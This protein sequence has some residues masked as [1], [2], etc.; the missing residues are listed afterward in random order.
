VGSKRYSGSGGKREAQKRVKARE[1]G[2]RWKVYAPI[3]T[4]LVVIG[5]VLALI[6][7]GPSVGVAVGDVAPNSQFTLLNGTTTQLYNFKG[8]YLLL[9]FI[10]TWCDGC[11]EGLNQLSSY[12]PMLQARGVQVL[13]LE[14]YNDL[15]YPGMELGKFVKQFGNSNFTA[16][17]ASYDMTLKYNS[18][19]YPDV[20]YLISPDG[21]VIYE[22]QDLST[23]LGNLLTIMQK[24]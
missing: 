23:G 8:H 18:K 17:Y 1:S 3:L 7:R 24:I 6:H 15:G 16:G 13:V 12:Y 14:S 10:T 9:Y 21:K 11:A 19:A 5:L 20:Y 2:R 4:S 22:G